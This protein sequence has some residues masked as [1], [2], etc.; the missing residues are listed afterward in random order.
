[1]ESMFLKSS[2][3][4]VQKFV[5]D[6]NVEIGGVTKR[7]L[8]GDLIR[9]DVEDSIDKPS[10]FNFVLEDNEGKWLDS[11]LLDPEIGPDIRI[12]MGYAGE[13]APLIAGKI[14]A[15]N[16]DFPSE[17]VQT[18]AVQGYDRS[19]FLQK[20]H[21]L[22]KPETLRGHDI[23]TLA[24]KIAT[25]NGLNSEIEETG[26]KCSDVVLMTPG[27][28]DYSFLK[29]IAEMAGFEIFVRDR[30]LYFKK[31]DYGKKN[32]PSIDDVDQG[33][34]LNWGEEISRMNL[35][36]S[37]ARVV[38]KAAVRVYH[39]KERKAYEFE[40]SEGNSEI[41]SGTLASKYV[42]KSEFNSQILEQNMVLSSQNDVD[43]LGKALMTQA[44][45]SFVE[46]WCELP[47][48]PRIRAGKPIE[49]GGAGKRLSGSYYIKSAKHSIGES[50]YILK[51]ELM[52]MVVH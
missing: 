47:G 33:A 11:S 40:K 17:G 2:K 22:T 43:I 36:L 8:V 39:P 23:S 13:T 50:G 38:K 32:D 26:I 45:N 31:P 27:E 44:N 34:R 19:F 14:V 7:D 29:R 51:L 5:P 20:T 35:R 10:M 12:F 15:L 24:R 42:A 37:T 48:D 28:S 6:F 25:L 52:S 4:S 9:A 18:L 3:K 21:C 1:M 16:P 41:F 49:I 30:K 46:G